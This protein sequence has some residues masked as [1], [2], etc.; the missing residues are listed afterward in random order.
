VSRDVFEKHPVGLA[1]TN[2]PGNM[3]PEVAGV[4]HT[5]TLSSRA[6]RLAGVSGEDAIDGAAPR[7]GVELL[8][9]IPDRCRVKAPGC[10][11][12]GKDGAGVGVDFDVCGGG[13]AR[14][15]KAKTHV[16]AAAAR[17]EG[18]TVSGR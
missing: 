11:G 17:T 18:E 1:L 14:L 2:D 15:G 9:I 8:E 12:C 3:G 5:A 6:E 7:G 10:H 4:G 16:K 13:K